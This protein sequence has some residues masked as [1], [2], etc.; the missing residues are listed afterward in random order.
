MGVTLRGRDATRPDPAG[1]HRLIQISDIGDDGGFR[2]RDFV[3]IS[4]RESFNDELLLR[5]GDLIFPNRGSRTTAAVFEA[6]E[7]PTLVGSQFFLIRP[8]HMSILPSY[9]AWTL[10]TGKAASYFNSHR[11]G[12]NVLTFKKDDLDAFEFPVPPLAIQR[13]VVGIDQLHHRASALE[14]RLASLR[15]LHLEQ[16]LLQKVTNA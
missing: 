11:R 12:T 3:P 7:Y 15:A 9:L 1:S 5:P 6:T 2:T 10:R 13:T 8:F 16:T 14:E 4:P